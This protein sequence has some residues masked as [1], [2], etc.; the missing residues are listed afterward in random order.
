MPAGP[1]HFGSRQAE[2]LAGRAAG[3]GDGSVEQAGAGPGGVVVGLEGGDPPEKTLGR[4][5]GGIA[6]PATT[7]GAAESGPPASEAPAPPSEAVGGTLETGHVEEHR[8]PA[9]AVGD[10]GHTPA[11]GLRT[12]RDGGDVSTREGVR[13]GRFPDVRQPYNSNR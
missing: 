1:E 7:A 4:G 10:R 5:H 8:L 9:V 6:Q 12:R 13:E 3:L 2:D 11:G